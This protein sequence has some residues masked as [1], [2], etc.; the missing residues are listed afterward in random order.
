MLSC[1]SHVLLFAILW[2]VAHQPPLTMGFSSPEYWNGLPYPFPGNLPNPEIKPRS[3]SLQ[4]DSLPANPP[5]KPKNTGVGSLSLL[6]GIFPTQE[7]NWGVLV[8]RQILYQLSYEGNPLFCKLI[9]KLK[10]WCVI[11][12]ETINSLTP[13]EIKSREIAQIPSE[14]CYIRKSMFIDSEKEEC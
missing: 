13:D 7:S 3:P 2:T 14:A 11:W 1:F 5:G 10:S 12:H 6:Q 4:V 8:C 9:E